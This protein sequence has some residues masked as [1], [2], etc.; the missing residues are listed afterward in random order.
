VCVP[1]VGYVGYVGSNLRIGG[2]EWARY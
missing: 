1:I 2:L